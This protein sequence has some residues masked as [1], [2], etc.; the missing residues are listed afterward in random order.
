VPD[1]EAL[2]RTAKRLGA[3][4]ELADVSL[5]DGTPRHDPRK[6]AMS[7]SRIVGEA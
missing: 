2:R 4:L 3:R 6:L 7:F 1:E 5:G